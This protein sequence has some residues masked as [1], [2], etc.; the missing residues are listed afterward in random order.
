MGSGAKSYMRKGFLI[1]EEMRKYF[2]I[3]EEAVSHIRLCTP[4]PLN[5][6]LDVE[7]FIFFFISVLCRGFP[8]HL[9]DYF[10]PVLC[11]TCEDESATPLF[12]GA[13]ACLSHR[14][15]G[16]GDW[17][18]TRAIGAVFPACVSTKVQY[19]RNGGRILGRNPVL[20]VFLLAIH[21]HFYSLALRLPFFK[22]MQPLTVFTV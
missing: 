15:Q 20:R 5:F 9:Y 16:E 19:S 8:A 22:L 18:S 14:L 6:L 11:A 4:I 21:S 3:H 12:L 17:S 7:I 10:W 2:T 1:C 13:C